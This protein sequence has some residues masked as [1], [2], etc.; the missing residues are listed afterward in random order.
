MSQQIAVPYTALSM[1]TPAARLLDLLAG[2]SA[3]VQDEEARSPEICDRQLDA[4]E[5]CDLYQEAGDAV[6]DVSLE[7]ERRVVEQFL[8]ERILPL[9]LR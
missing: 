3:F 7:D 8:C 4:Q 5:L 1:K 2:W 9:L 6:M